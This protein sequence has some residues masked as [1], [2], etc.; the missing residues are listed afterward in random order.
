VLSKCEFLTISSNCEDSVAKTLSNS[1]HPMASIVVMHY[2]KMKYLQIK[3][4]ILKNL[5]LIN[6][7]NYY[8]IIFIALISVKPTSADIQNE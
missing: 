5:Y 8:K 2:L 6:V 3:I 1:S 4:F 7:K